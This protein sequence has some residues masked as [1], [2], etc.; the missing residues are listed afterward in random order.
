MSSSHQS[1]TM[2]LEQATNNYR[3]MVTHLLTYFT[4][5]QIVSGKASLSDYKYKIHFPLWNVI[6][7]VDKY[8]GI[9]ARV[10]WA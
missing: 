7:A 4:I 1:T 9:L 6:V 2:S 10:V 8:T 3:K 5:L